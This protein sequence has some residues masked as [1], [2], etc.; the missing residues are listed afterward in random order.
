[1]APWPSHVRPSELASSPIVNVHVHFDR[2]VTDVAFL[3]GL[4]TQAQ[5][6]FDRTASVRS[7]Q[8][9]VPGRF[10][11]GSGQP[12]RHPSRGPGPPGNGFPASPAPGGQARPASLSTFVTREH[13]ATFRA[14]PGSAVHRA[15]TR[16][17]LPG[18]VLAGAWTATGWPPTMEGAVRSGISAARA[19]LVASGQRDGLPPLPREAGA[20]PRAGLR[21]VA[22]PHERQSAPDRPDRPD[23]PGHAIEPAIGTERACRP[24][25]EPVKLEEVV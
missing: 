14:T 15:A 22:A 7:H 2:R 16:T 24:L 10:D 21:P 8:R 25:L 5:W 19:V 23:R 13:H 11:I 12:H 17:R 9:A 18:L 6:V 1:M 3:A 20:R 4:G